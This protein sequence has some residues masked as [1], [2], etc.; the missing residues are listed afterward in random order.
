MKTE[1]RKICKAKRA[2]LSELEYLN[3]SAD[4]VDKLIPLI[5]KYDKIGIYLPLEG[6]VDVRAI[7]RLDRTF[8]APV[9]V[10][11]KT[12]NFYEL[13]SIDDTQVGKFGIL[14]PRPAHSIEPNDLEVIIV[15]LIAF[16]TNLHRLGQGKGY[17]DRYLSQTKA[18]KIGVG[19][20]L[21]KIDEVP[22]E[23]FDVRLDYIVTEK[24][25]YH[26]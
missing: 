26:R 13:T 10:D 12:M 5:L 24:N 17:F 6:E 21:Q 9:V 22:V 4:V 2:E 23:S 1:L 14:E 7:L 11:D 18:L 19:F 15:P 25:V 20:E 16:D 8:F 3:Y